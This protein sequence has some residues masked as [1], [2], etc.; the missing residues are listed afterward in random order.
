MWNGQPPGD[1][2]ML[3]G[4]GPAGFMIATQIMFSLFFLIAGRTC[5]L[6]SFP[7]EMKH[8]PGC[9]TLAL[10]WCAWTQ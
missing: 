6:V 3:R 7:V 2:H 10:I 5:G 1:G 9:A 8:A 4:A